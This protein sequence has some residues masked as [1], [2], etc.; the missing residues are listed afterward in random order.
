MRRKGPPKRGSATPESL[1]RRRVEMPT[2][3]LPIGACRYC[4]LPADANEPVVVEFFKD[5]LLHSACL[6]EWKDRGN[7]S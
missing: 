3:S 7:G 5:F 4:G 1:L 6:Q 2:T